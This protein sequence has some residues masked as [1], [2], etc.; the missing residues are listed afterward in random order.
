MT[1]V[2]IRGA[3]LLVALVLFAPVAAIA[4][5]QAALII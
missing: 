3:G 4:L 1:K 2:L 5:R